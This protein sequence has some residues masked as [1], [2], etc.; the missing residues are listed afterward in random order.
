MVGGALGVGHERDWQF[1]LLK[2]RSMIE[3]F[4][5]EAPERVENVIDRGIFKGG[6]ISF[7]QEIS[8]LGDWWHW[9]CINGPPRDL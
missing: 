3:A 8:G 4:I 6:S 9:T 1:A 7:L 2:T 5:R